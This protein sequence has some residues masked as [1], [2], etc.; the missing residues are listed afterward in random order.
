MFYTAKFVDNK[1]FFITFH[2]P[3][4]SLFT[5]FGLKA[6]S[7]IKILSKD[8]IIHQSYFILDT[9]TNNYQIWFDKINDD[10]PNVDN[11]IRVDISDGNVITN[12]YNTL[13]SLNEFNVSYEENIINIEC[14]DVGNCNEPRDYNTG[15][16]F[17]YQLK[18]Y[19]RNSLLKNGFFD[20]D[21]I[22][23]L[24]ADFTGSNDTLELLVRSK[25]KT[26]FENGY[27]KDFGFEYRLIENW[28]FGD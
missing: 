10:S 21:I 12:L 19:D 1:N 22:E 2:G 16:E 13:D 8:E 25:K 24:D 18:G 15:F 17:L 28:F 23:V 20:R 11:P 26:Y 4:I 5:S 3:T 6:S 14:K 27:R 7:S 9:P